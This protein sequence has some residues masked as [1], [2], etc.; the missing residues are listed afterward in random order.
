MELISVEEA[1]SAFDE[2]Q[3]ISRCLKCHGSG[4]VRSRTK[5]IMCLDEVNPAVIG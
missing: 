4:T 2:T 1:L 3:V 5:P